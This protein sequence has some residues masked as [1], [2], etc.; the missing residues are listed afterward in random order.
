MGVLCLVSQVWAGLSLSTPEGYDYMDGWSHL[1]ECKNQRTHMSS[2][3][4]WVQG[5]NPRL[6]EHTRETRPS[7]ISGMT[8][9]MPEQGGFYI[10]SE[11]VPVPWVWYS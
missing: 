10:T 6:S 9:A 7:A 2:L 4:L 5:L 8:Y 1:S 11:R 3:L